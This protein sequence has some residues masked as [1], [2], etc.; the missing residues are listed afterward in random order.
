MI[1]GGYWVAAEGR[2]RLPGGGIAGGKG[3]VSP[4]GTLHAVDP[5]TEQVLCG[6]P[7][8]GLA[9]FRE[10]E[11]SRLRFGVRCRRCLEV[12]SSRRLPAGPV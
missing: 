11:W 3:A 1:H 6:E 8:R 7:I 10:I 9:A 4:A 12:E 5:L 2:H